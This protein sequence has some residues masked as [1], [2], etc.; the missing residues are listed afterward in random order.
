MF[1]VSR[2]FVAINILRYLAAHDGALVSSPVIAK[3]I[4]VPQPYTRKVANQLIRAGLIKSTRG[5]SGGLTLA[6]AASSIRLGDVWTVVEETR[7][8]QA[9]ENEGNLLPA[10]LIDDA[11]QKFLEVLNEH[12]IAEFLAQKPARKSTRQRGPAR[13]HAGFSRLNSFVFSS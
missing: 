10:G 3:E 8:G 2:T 5:S 6:R 7:V 13:D 1:V 11:T 4:S 12:S 9:F